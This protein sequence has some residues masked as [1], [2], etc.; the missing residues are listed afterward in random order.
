MRR[1]E[2][3]LGRCPEPRE[4]DRSSLFASA[5]HP[6]ED[7]A[8]FEIEVALSDLE[9]ALCR[10]GSHAVL[11]VPPDP[12]ATLLLR[13]L[14]KRLP[15]SPRVLYVAPTPGEDGICARILGELRQE[16]GDDA[17]ARLLGL[18][19]D[20]ATRGEAL[21]LVIGDAG[22]MQAQALGCLG[23]LARASRSGLRLA[24]I[25]ATEPGSDGN[26][27]AE[28]VA[29]LGVGAEKVVLRTRP[30]QTQT[31]ALV[32]TPLEHS[33]VD[34]DIPPRA[35]AI[36]PEPA[37]PDSSAERGGQAS[38]SPGEA[39]RAAEPPGYASRARRWPLGATAALG[40]ALALL[41]IQLRSAATL[42]RAAVPEPAR[43]AEQS[44]PLQASVSATTQP[45]PSRPKAEPAGSD[46][47]ASGAAHMRSEAGKRPA[48]RIRAAAAPHVHTIPVSLNARPWARIEVDGR[49]V[50]ITPLAD[51]PMAP[52]LHRFRAHLADGRVIERTLRIDAY[53]N[54]ISFP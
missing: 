50:G 47:V 6:G 30:E 29:A 39:I 12:S 31:E 4:S 40:I 7:V 18:V 8:S 46:D 19:Q 27:I 38:R 52:G 24:L 36:G 51:L 21:V 20:L 32:R 26:A 11:A 10:D 28:L 13:A 43:G 5:D 48:A 49:E 22:S 41:G 9:R 17:E 25:V 35:T 45:A 34:R 54:H 37:G 44:E 33:E 23:R 14:M 2:L 3:I 16:P 42:P 1:T 15:G 53:R